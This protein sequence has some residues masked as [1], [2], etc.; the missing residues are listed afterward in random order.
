MAHLATLGLNA[1]FRPNYLAAM[2]G[3]NWVA[4]GESM[5]CPAGGCFRNGEAACG[6]TQIWRDLM[7]KTL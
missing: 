7:L 3:Y 6:Q 2:G 1:V 4:Y 5:P